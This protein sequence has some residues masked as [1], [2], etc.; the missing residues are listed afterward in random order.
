MIH[1]GGSEGVGEQ[2][3]V[4]SFKRFCVNFMQKICSINALSLGAEWVVGKCK[5]FRKKNRYVGPVRTT[6]GNP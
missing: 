2:Q 3:P 1:T 6:I 5:F 4:K